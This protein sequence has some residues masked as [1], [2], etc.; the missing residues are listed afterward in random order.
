MDDLIEAYEKTLSHKKAAIICNIPITRAYKLLKDYDLI[1]S[2]NQRLAKIGNKNPNW[3]SGKIHLAPLHQWVHRNK[4][5]SDKCEN[6]GRHKKLDAA[7][8]SGTYKRD[9][10]DFRWLCRSCHMMEDGRI[11]NLKQ[12]AR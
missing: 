10:N 11:K 12:Y 9:I 6:C 4:P 7:N 3:K 1:V 2:E 5:M 8:I